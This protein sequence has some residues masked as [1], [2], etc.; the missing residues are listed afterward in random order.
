MSTSQINS[1]K[2]ILK[3][4][5]VFLELTPTQIAKTLHVSNSVISKHISGEKT[6]YPCDIFLIE[7]I[8]HIKVKEY[9]KICQ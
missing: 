2:K 4:L 8:F 1:K 3:I 9:S 6:Y 5:L 7:Q